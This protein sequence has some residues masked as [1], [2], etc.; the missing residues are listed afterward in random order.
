M[1]SSSF[2]KRV[3]MA[4]I[5]VPAILILV[6]L[7]PYQHHLAFCL[8]ICAICFLGSQEMHG[9]LSKDGERLSPLAYSGFLLPLAQYLQFRFLPETELT[10]YTLITLC[11][12]TFAAEVFTGAHDGFAKTW[13]RNAKAVMNI[14][15]PGLFASFIIR[16][17]FFPYPH[18][19]ILLF[20]LIVFSS[21]T[22]AF[23]FG[24]LLGRGNKGIVKVSPNKSI[25][26][27]IGGVLTPGILTALV[28]YAAPDVLTFSVPAGF[29]I[30]M[31]TGIAG[32]IGDLIESSFKRSAAV[33]DSGTIVMGRGGV[34]DSIDSIVMAAPVYTALMVVSVGIWTI[35]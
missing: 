24:M 34:L 27:F 21:D 2:K 5:L 26:G 23:I 14:I 6:L 12:L 19:F 25:A 15:Y 10:F 1:I 32:T 3:I 31:L 16:L 11:G 4:L 9:L 17:A 18:W 8:A 20:F 29:L 7:L 33:K 22:F 28:A 35:Y 13:E 30:G